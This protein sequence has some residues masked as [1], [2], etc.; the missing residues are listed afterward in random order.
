MNSRPSLSRDNFFYSVNFICYVQ[1]GAFVLPSRRKKFGLFFY[2]FGIFAA[3]W[4]N[5]AREYMFLFLPGWLGNELRISFSNWI[6]CYF[7]ESPLFCSTALLTTKIKN[8]MCRINFFYWLSTLP[9][10]VIL[11]NPVKN[12]TEKNHLSWTLCAF[13]FCPDF[14][15]TNRLFKAK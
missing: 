12:S 15:A 6:F 2:I 10:I 14:L 3:E 8:K 4:I 1:K 13:V 5:I 7:H 11:S 9:Y